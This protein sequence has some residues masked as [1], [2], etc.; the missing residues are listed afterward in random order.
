[1]NRKH[2]L[3]TKA[4]LKNKKNIDEKR[5][6]IE[7]INKNREKSN[8][9]NY[10]NIIIKKEKKILESIIYKIE[11]LSTNNTENFNDFEKQDSIKSGETIKKNLTTDYYSN[12]FPKIDN[13]YRK[14]MIENF[15]KNKVVNVNNEKKYRTNIFNRRNIDN[16]LIINNDEQKNIKYRINYNDKAFKN[17]YPKINIYQPKNYKDI[18]CVLSG[19]VHGDRLIQLIS[20]CLNI[21]PVPM[22]L[23]PRGDLMFIWGILRGSEILLKNC[24]LKNKNFIYIDHC[25]FSDYRGHHQRR[26]CYRMVLNERQLTSILDVPEDRWKSLNIKMAN[27]WQKNN[28]D[29]LIAP[30]TDAIKAFYNICENW[31]EKILFSL[32][33]ITD[34][35]VIIRYKPNSKTKRDDYK[36]LSSIYKNLEIQDERIPINRAFDN[37]KVLITHSSNISIDAIIRGIPVICDKTCASSPVSSLDLN[38]LETNNIYKDMD[39]VYKWLCSLSYSQFFED[40]IVSGKAFEILNI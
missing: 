36:K 16:K 2:F 37:V 9:V 12:K 7:N 14:S 13:I 10:N 32:K 5:V 33:N 38:D 27:S 39:L 21:K 19:S 8:I 28:S 4:Q 1:M 3:F 20:K 11:N 23:D 17:L 29:I 35:K 18:Y 6:N 26:R 31:I 40:E 24:I 22:F 30:P 25:Y 15:V 34:R